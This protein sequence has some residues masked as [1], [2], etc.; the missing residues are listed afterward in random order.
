MKINDI[1][2]TPYSE[3][4]CYALVSKVSKEY[5]GVELPTVADYTKDSAPVVKSEQTK[6][7]WIEI[8]GFAPGSIVVLGVFA[9][10]ARHVGI[11]LDD[12]NV[13]HTCYRYGAIIQN[14][15]QLNMAGYKHR[16]YYKLNGE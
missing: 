10:D 16:R 8:D 9:D 14:T 7:R 3:L 15:S 5:F 1:I 6:S 12:G 13:L 2:G 11:C 4:D